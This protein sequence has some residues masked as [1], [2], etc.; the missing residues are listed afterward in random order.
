MTILSVEQ[1]SLNINALLQAVQWIRQ[2]LSAKRDGKEF[3]SFPQEVNTDAIFLAHLTRKFQLSTFERNILLLC[4]GMA[5]DPTFPELLAQ[6]QGN[7][8]LAYPTFSLALTA[9]PEPHW[10]ILSTENPLK[11]WQL[12]EVDTGL[13]PTT[14]PLKIDECIL[15][16]L[17]GEKTFDE[18]LKSFVNFLPDEVL[19]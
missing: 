16:Y 4:V 9:L 7:S 1:K 18:Q 8:K 6:V 13:S 3:P 5:I 10:S 14:A 2:C 15:C 12:I 17:L 11:L 19:S